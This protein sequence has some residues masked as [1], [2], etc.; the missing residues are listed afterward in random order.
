M[1]EINTVSAHHV[2]ENSCVDIFGLKKLI[3]DIGV[4]RS[5]C[6]RPVA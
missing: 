3:I 2:M 4:S 5:F 6:E 1:I